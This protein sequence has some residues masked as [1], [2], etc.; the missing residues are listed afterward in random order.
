MDLQYRRPD[1][2]FVATVNGYPYHVTPSDPLFEEAEAEADALG[3]D[4]PFE[5]VPEPPPVTLDDF[6]R[7]IQVVVDD[8][9]RERRYDNGNSLA[10][11]VNS[12][13]E[14]WAAEATAFVA[15]RD[16]VWAYAYA[17]LADVEAGNRETPTIPE[18]LGELPTLTWPE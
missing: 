7:A 10:S 4:L 3:D 11:Y 18:L 16:Q 6:R 9:A 8:K 12:T 2:T 1:G 5:P 15:W 14:D 17:A 13:V